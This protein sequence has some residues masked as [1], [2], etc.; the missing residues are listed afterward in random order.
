MSAKIIIAGTELNFPDN[1]LFFQGYINHEGRLLYNE[2]A[3]EIIASFLQAKSP[4]DLFAEINGSFQFIYR[5]GNK[6]YFSVDHFGGYSLFYRLQNSSLTLFDNPMLLPEPGPLSDL[7]ICTFLATGFTLGQN[8]V[9]KDLQECLPGTLYTYDLKTEKLSFSRWFSYYAIDEKM[10]DNEI[11]KSLFDNLFPAVEAGEY[12][13]SL[14]GGI[15]SR[16]L[17]GVLLKQKIPFQTYTFGSDYNPDRK[18]AASLAESFNIPC[19]QHNFTPELC[20]Q[21]WTT[22]D[23]AFIIKNCTF[24]RSLPNE[25]DLISSHLLD[26]RQHII[27]K[28]FGG[29]WLTGRYLTSQLLLCDT[30]KKLTRYL[31][32]KYFRLTGF[33][34]SAFKNLLFDCFDRFMQKNYYPQNPGFVSAE[35]Q[36]NLQHHERK[37]IVNTISFYKARGFRFYLPY[38][39]RSLMQ[40]FSHLQYNFKLEQNGYF[41]FLKNYYFLEELSPLREFP[42]LRGNF[43]AP[44]HPSFLQNWKSS[45]HTFLRDLDE[46]KLRKRYFLPSLTEYGDTLMLFRRDIN[47]LPYLRQK[48]GNNFP[49]L[50]PLIETLHKVNSN[51]AAAHLNWLSRQRTSQLNVNA[52]TLC[53]IFFNP[54]FLEYLTFFTA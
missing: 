46:K 36:W 30:E 11:L 7:N 14:S 37:Y 9:F 52:L 27:V 54:I 23:I 24:A 1:S 53:Y 8:T 47:M 22:D 31:F 42:T 29:D 33:S 50:F 10:P 51:Q 20:N 21:Y 48:V 19:H 49:S 5:Q 25:T 38:Y 45:F 43:L 3:Q 35:E 18:L 41:Q 16:L 39:D 32:K 44:F 28:G 4:A 17:F 12:T 26:P 2:A 34:S 40:Y 15:D 6:L 13:L